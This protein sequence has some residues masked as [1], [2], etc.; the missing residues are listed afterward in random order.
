MDIKT[1]EYM[2][3]RVN[4]GRRITK[5]LSALRDGVELLDKATR[6][7][8]LTVNTENTSCIDMQRRYEGNIDNAN[9]LPR[10]KY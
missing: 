1:L 3:A 8:G 9:M 10:A 6:M 2:E 4:K 5:Q 7:D